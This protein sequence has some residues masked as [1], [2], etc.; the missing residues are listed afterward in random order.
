MLFN[1][2]F[3]LQQPARRSPRRRGCSRSCPR[4]RECGARAPPSSRL[5]SGRTITRTAQ[6]G[7]LIVRGTGYEHEVD[8]LVRAGQVQRDHLG[9]GRIVASETEAPDM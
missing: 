1:V 4:T 6:C 5:G 7:A 8:M 3:G 2:V 9:F